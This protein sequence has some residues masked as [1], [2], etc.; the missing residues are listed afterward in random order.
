MMRLTL[1]TVPQAYGYGRINSSFLIIIT[2]ILNLNRV[3]LNTQN[4]WIPQE[5][6]HPDHTTRIVS[7]PLFASDDDREGCRRSFHR[8]S[9]RPDVPA[10]SMNITVKRRAVRRMTGDLIS[11]WLIARGRTSAPLSTPADVHQRINFA[12][13]VDTSDKQ[14]PAP[15]PQIFARKLVAFRY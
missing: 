10:M 11:R 5:A 7:P 4:T 13:L 14:E 2:I 8:A 3:C 12:L 9:Q 1:L 15:C 6:R